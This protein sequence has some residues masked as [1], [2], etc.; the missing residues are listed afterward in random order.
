MQQTGR[1]RELKVSF[2]E[3]EYERDRVVGG[4][5]RVKMDGMS[6]ENDEIIATFHSLDPSKY[7]DLFVPMKDIVRIGRSKSKKNDILLNNHDCSSVHCELFIGRQFSNFDLNLLTVRDLSSNGTFINDVCIGRN[8][9]SLLRDGDRLSFSS[10]L[11]YIVRYNMK[12]KS[13]KKSF[14]DKYIMTDTI[15]GTG[16]YAQV[17]EAVNRKTGVVFA[18]KI[19][20]PTTKEDQATQL[21]R[22][23]EILVN[24]NHPNIIGFYDTYLEPVSANTLT[25]LLV[26]EKIN[27][28]EL[29]NRIVKKGKLSQLETKEICKQLLNGLKYLHSM[30]IVHRDLKPE[31]ILLSIDYKTDDSIVSNGPWDVNEMSVTVKIADFGLAK[32]IGNRKFT[33]T[34]YWERNGWKT[35]AGAMVANQDLIKDCRNLYKEIKASGADIDIIKVKGHSGNHGNDMADKLAVDG[36][37]K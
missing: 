17:K 10:Q 3:A 5:K 22:E 33:T 8:N 21:N 15:L 25:T 18:V 30:N 13:E 6:I 29:F 1:K 9:S 28:G 26:L 14:F 16:H 24:L 20:N 19:F 2:Q 31:N 4:T 35:S 34:L 32:F 11:H 27:G 36:C 37:S 12:F 7:S 23:L